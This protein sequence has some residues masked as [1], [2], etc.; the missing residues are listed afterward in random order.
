[1]TAEEIKVGMKVRFRE[2]DDME[3]EYGSDP[4]GDIL[5]GNVYFVQGMDYLCGK[6]FFVE[7]LIPRDDYHVVILDDPENIVDDYTIVPEM[8]EPVE[9]SAPRPDPIAAEMLLAM[10][11]FLER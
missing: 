5:L 4:D 7:E 3:L 2:M 10:F 8:L 9:G 1:M 6:E 11:S